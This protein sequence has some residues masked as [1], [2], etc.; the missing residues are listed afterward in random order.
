[1]VKAVAR[2]DGGSVVVDNCMEPVFCRS[3]ERDGYLVNRVLDPLEASYQCIM[4][5]I[6][7]DGGTGWGCALDI[8]MATGVSIQVLI[9]YIDLRRRG[10]KPR[11]GARERTLWVEWG[12]RR[13]EFLILEE[14][15]VFTFKELGEWSRLAAGDGYIPVLAI[16]DR[17][18]GVTYYEARVVEE[19][20]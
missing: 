3:L 2:I 14:G 18:G 6:R 5:G 4:D 17:V 11:N 12:S 20:S 9:V 8:A 10:R 16:V 1:M 15:D 19:I 13:Y 7:I